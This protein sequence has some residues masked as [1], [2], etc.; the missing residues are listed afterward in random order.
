VAGRP[1][2]RRVGSRAHLRR[3]KA[4]ARGSRNRSRRALLF[5]SRTKLSSVPPPPSAYR[6][7]FHAVRWPSAMTTPNKVVGAWLAPARQMS[8]GCSL[9]TRHRAPSLVGPSRGHGRVP[10][11]MGRRVP[12]AGAPSSGRRARRKTSGESS[13]RRRRSRRGARMP[14]PALRRALGRLDAP[15]VLPRPCA[16]HRR[17]HRAARLVRLE[18]A[19]TG[20][21]G[22][23][24]RRVLL[25]RHDVECTHECVK[26]R[27]SRR[28][29]PS[30]T[31]V[32]LETSALTEAE[33]V[34]G[35][36]GRS[37]IVE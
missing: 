20:W 24:T 26:D 31:F 37:L 19:A 29:R 25:G 11:A 17:L 36:S 10:R 33:D 4:R 23:C 22:T 6:N 28:P 5:G 15:S 27:F 21:V 18:P 32:G 12:P 8:R 34:M 2:R 16:F 13:W 7:A 3:C 14:Q 1:S 30:V 35:R 9:S